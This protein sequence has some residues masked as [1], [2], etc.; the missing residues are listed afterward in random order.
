[1]DAIKIYNGRAQKGSKKLDDSKC[2]LVSAFTEQM[3]HNIEWF[4][5]DDGA[6]KQW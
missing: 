4:E 5:L 6:Q 3:L 1:L 2:Y